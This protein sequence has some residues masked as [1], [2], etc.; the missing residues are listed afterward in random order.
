MLF[1]PAIGILWGDPK[2]I[3]PVFYSP[4]FLANKLSKIFYVSQQAVSLCVFPAMVWK[5]KKIIDSTVK[6][7]VP[8]RK[9]RS[10]APYSFLPPYLVKF[11]TFIFQNPNNKLHSHEG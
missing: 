4:I 6:S 5:K 3:K 1:L 11:L 2:P 8:A 9:F 7:L 10:P